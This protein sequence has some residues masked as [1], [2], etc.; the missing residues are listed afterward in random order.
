MLMGKRETFVVGK[1][2]YAGMKRLIKEHATE[3]FKDHIGHTIEFQEDSPYVLWIKCLD[4]NKLW[5]HYD[6]DKTSG[7]PLGILDY[8]AA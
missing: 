6:L 4:C 5:T 7:R 8:S 2:S 3:L 1:P